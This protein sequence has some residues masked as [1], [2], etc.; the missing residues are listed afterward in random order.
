MKLIDLFDDSTEMRVIQFLFDNPTFEFTRKEIKTEA[1]LE[2]S[3]N[4]VVDKF[5]EIGLI[6]PLEGEK[7]RANRGNTIY[8]KLARLELELEKRG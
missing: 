8:M 2:N 3:V 6:I 7:F 1:K 4:R 5:I